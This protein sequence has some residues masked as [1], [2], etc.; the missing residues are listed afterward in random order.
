MQAS[1]EGIS[2]GPAREA[3]DRS[4]STRQCQIFDRNQQSPDFGLTI[5]PLF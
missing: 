3:G 4:L 5:Q 1:W 2:F